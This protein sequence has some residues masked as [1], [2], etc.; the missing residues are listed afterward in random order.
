MIEREFYNPEL[1]R[2]GWY[3]EVWKTE[4]IKVRDEDKLLV[5]NHYWQDEDGELWVDFNNPMENVIHGFAAYRTRKGYLVPDEIRELREQFGVTVE[6]YA[7]L[8][9]ITPVSLKQIES[10]QYIQT[11]HQEDLFRTITA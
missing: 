5:R 7:D 9:G 4:F 11:K 1:E 2:S 8:L 6:S 3:Q 10:N